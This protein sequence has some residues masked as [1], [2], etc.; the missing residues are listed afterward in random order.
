MADI[1]YP[2]DNDDRYTENRHDN[3]ED[4]LTDRPDGNSRDGR[5]NDVTFTSSSPASPASPRGSFL[6]TTL[7]AVGFTALGVV[8]ASQMDWTGHSVAGDKKTSH[9]TQLNVSQI[10][11]T[12]TGAQV[13]K[14]D[15]GE[16]TS[17]FVPVIERVSEAVVSVTAKRKT[18]SSS[19]FHRGNAPEATS[20]GTAFF[21]RPDGYLLT[22][23]HVV[24][25][26]ETIEVRTTKGFVYQAKLVGLDPA[27]DLAVFKVDTDDKL[28]FI[29]FGDSEKLRVGDWAIAIGNPF[30]QQGLS[31]TVTVGVVSAKGRSS[32]RFGAESPDYQDYIQVDAAINPGN[33]GGPLLNLKGEAVGINSA[34]S[35]PT[36]SSVGIGFSVPINLARAIVPDLIA[37]GEVRRAWLGVS[38]ADVTQADARRLHL[39][40]VRGVVVQQV[41]PNSPAAIAGIQPDDIIVTFRDHDVT[42]SSQLSILVSTAHDGDKAKIGIIRGGNHKVLTARLTDKRKGDILASSPGASKRDAGEAVSWGGLELRTFTREIAAR[43][44]LEFAEGVVVIGV[45]GRSEAKRSGFAPGDVITEVGGKPVRNV[46]DFKRITA[47]LSDR[48]KRVPMIV[49]DRMGNTEYRSVRL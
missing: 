6:K 12:L 3:P 18:K 17:P 30:P 34:I 22:N 24:E 13:V 35:S 31:G 40:E 44:G 46:S 9:N 21:F 33:S 15:D 16:Y 14:D 10:D 37:Y 36:G 5:G 11:A 19:F 49:I 38:M 26:A 45:S 7:L 32:L 25:G 4:D 28:T 39:N 48:T 41:V 27:T 2:H 20:S 29:P 23:N 42:N 47:A 1:Q 8:I 43:N